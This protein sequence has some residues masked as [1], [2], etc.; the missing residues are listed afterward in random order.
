MK[1]S[2]SPRRKIKN[3]WTTGEKPVYE[4]IKGSAKLKFVYPIYCPHCGRIIEITQTNEP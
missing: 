1:I 2:N 3:K 4:V